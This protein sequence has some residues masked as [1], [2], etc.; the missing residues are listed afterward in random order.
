MDFELSEEH[1]MFRKTVRDFAE[2]EIAPLI[3]VAE[4][5]QKFPKEII[6][7]A[8]KQKRHAL[9]IGPP[10]TGKSM[11]AQG[12]AELLPAGELQDVL[13]FENPHNESE[14][15][16]R[17][18]PSFPDS[19]YLMKHK[20][21][22]PFYSPQELTL[23]DRLTKEKKAQQLPRALKNSLGRRMNYASRAAETQKE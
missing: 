12:M 17:T 21:S 11:L 23:I 2:K 9:L 14:P 4:K 8:A 19:H 3:E 1:K 10:G 22:I 20:E 16:I 13:A 7:K 15:L 5:E 6:K 18:V